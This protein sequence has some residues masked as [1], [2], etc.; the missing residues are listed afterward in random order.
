[1]LERATQNEAAERY[2]DI[3]EFWDDFSKLRQ[4]IDEHELDSVRNYQVHD[5]PQPQVSRG[6]SPIAPVQP[7]FNT[8]RDLKLKF[9]AIA[10][11]RGTALTTG[12]LAAEN[13]PQEIYAAEITSADPRDE[14]ILEPAA[15][16]R[17]MEHPVRRRSS[18]F[19]RKAAVFVI[20]IT[21][22][23]GI[24]YGTHRY[25]RAAGFLADVQSTFSQTATANTDIFLRPGPNTNNDPIG[26]VTK[27][28]KVRIVNSQN[29]WYQVDVLEQGRER[30]NQGEVTRG[31]LNG[32][33]LDMD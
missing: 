12:F 15:Q 27:N 18:S 8:S 20:S 10:A 3:D 28:S 25:L 29:N 11:A 7:R 4:F 30:P 2:Q 23:V 13:T 31:W 24:L 14:I 5:K 9:P 16:V 22:F 19:L 33:Y 32:R 21:A 17:E 6:Y 26:L 1:V